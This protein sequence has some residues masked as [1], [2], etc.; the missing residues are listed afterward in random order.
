MTH[1]RCTLQRSSTTLLCLRII[2]YQATPSRR[3][4]TMTTLLPKLYLGFL[5]IHRGE[6]G[7]G[8]PDALQEERV[9]PAGVTTSVLARPT[10]ISPDPQKTHPR[11]INRACC[12]WW[13]VVDVG[14]D[15]PCA[16]WITSPLGTPRGRYDEYSGEFSLSLR[17]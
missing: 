10:R 14:A 11:I 7:R 13:C 12:V 9:A 3:N 2:V 15:C 8:T 6:W 5:S 17:N 1:H 16:W 4:A